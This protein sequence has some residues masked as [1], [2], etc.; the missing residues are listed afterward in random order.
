MKKFIAA[1]LIAASVVSFP[2]TAFMAGTPDQVEVLYNGTPIEFDVNP[3]IDAEANRTMVPMRA[4]FEAVGASVVWDEETRTVIAVRGEVGDSSYVA[5]QI[6][7]DEAQV[8]GETK[9]MDTSA[10]IIGDRTF[11]PLRFVTEALGE[12][13]DWDAENCTV[14]ITSQEDK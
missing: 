7:R 12:K 4:I 1:A 5:L 11:V 3:F 6:G 10:A 2:A 9:K 14:L 13:V 8:N